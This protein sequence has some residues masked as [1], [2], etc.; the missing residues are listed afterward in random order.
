[1]GIQHS[2]LRSVRRISQGS[3]VIYIFLPKG[4][5]F[6]RFSISSSK[7][8][9]VVTGR[10]VVMAVAVPVAVAAAVVVALDQSAKVTS[11]ITQVSN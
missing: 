1:M 7:F 6:L 10:A 5:P 8:V 2:E 3:S 9:V 4:L 11:A